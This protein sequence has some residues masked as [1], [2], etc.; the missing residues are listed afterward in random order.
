[1]QNLLKELE[2]ILKEEKEFVS[3]D[4]KLLKNSVIEAGLRPDSSL[5]RLLIGNETTKKAFFIEVGTALV[6][7]KIAFQKFVS[8][9][10]FLAN[11]YTSFKNKIGLSDGGDGYLRQRNDVVINWAYKDCVLEGGMTKEEKERDEVF[12]NTI[13]APDEITRLYAPKVFTN[14]EKWDAKAVKKG[15]A[16]KVTEIKSTDNLLIKGN[17]LLALHCLKERYAGKVKLIYS[18][19]PYNT[20]GDANSFTYNNSFNHSTWLTFMKNRLEICK[21]LLSDDGFMVISIDHCEL[22]YLGV[23]ADE[24]FGR[25]NRLG[26]VTVLVNSAGRQFA[27]FFSHTTDYILIYAKNKNE[28]KFNDVIVDNEKKRDFSEKDEKGFYKLQNLARTGRP[29]EEVENKLKKDRDNIFYPIYVSPDLKNISVEK[30]SGYYEVLPVKNNREYYWQVKKPTFTKRLKSGE[31]E[32]AAVMSDEGEVYVCKKYREK[33][34]LKTHWFDS[35][36]NSNFHGT[37]LLERLIGK[38]DKNTS[39]PKS[40]YTIIDILKIMTKDNDIV[41]DINGGS[42]TT[43]QAVLDLNKED[44]G[45]RSFVLLEQLEKHVSVTKRRLDKLISSE[46]YTYCELKEW[47]ERY[48]QEIRKAKTHA[49]I[50]KTYEAIKRE[51]FYRYDVNM[52]VFKTKDFG[53]LSLD[54]QKEALCKCL[55]VNHLY[56]NYSERDDARY[57]VTEEEKELTKKL[58]GK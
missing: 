16:D 27:S 26:I 8:N 12:Y 23:L 13:L 29:K 25:D 48:I 42:G 1:M 4:G 34:V 2:I 40:L 6:F 3:D 46:A 35:K 7:D 14:F 30:K 33:Q 56:V 49:D 50:K 20:P 39:Y 28:A 18:D 47:N 11:S 17:N 58:Y 45:D 15:M 21:E 55:D 51:A 37:R 44:G 57:N 10:Q 41:L 52:E 38:T 24:I 36:Y 22:L 19:P 9:K 32:Y 54:E 31:D 5:L 53:E 43:G